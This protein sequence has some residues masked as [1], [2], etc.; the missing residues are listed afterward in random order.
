[1]N[2]TWTARHYSVSW[3]QFKNQLW[4]LVNA[5]GLRNSKV[6]LSLSWAGVRNRGCIELCACRMMQALH[7]VMY[8]TDHVPAKPGIQM[9]VSYSCLWWP[10]PAPPEN[11]EGDSAKPSIFPEGKLHTTHAEFYWK[12]CSVLPFRVEQRLPAMSALLPPFWLALHN[13]RFCKRNSPVARL[14]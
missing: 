13:L 11:Y 12:I 2:T 6:C 9:R 1:M 8:I 7:C 14:W 10:N 4:L 3:E 5:I